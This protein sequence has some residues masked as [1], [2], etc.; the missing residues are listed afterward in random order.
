M[1]NP[2]SKNQYHQE[3]VEDLDAAS[4]YDFAYSV[5]SEKTGDI[6]SHRESRNKDGMVKGVYMFIE[7]DGHKRTVNYYVNKDSGF[8]ADVNREKVSGYKVPEQTKFVQYEQHEQQYEQPKT[9]QVASFEDSSKYLVEHTNLAKLPLQLPAFDLT[10]YKTKFNDDTQSNVQEP[11]KYENDQ[12]QTVQQTEAVQKPTFNTEELHQP[13]NHYQEVPTFLAQEQLPKKYENAYKPFQIVAQ[14]EEKLT[15]YEQH[16]DY[17][18]LETPELK[19]EQYQ[20]SSEHQLPNTE[21]DQSKPSDFSSQYQQEEF[22]QQTGPQ[23]F[24][25]T[26][27]E[28]LQHQEALK[29]EIDGHAHPTSTEQTSIES[30]QFV[31]PKYEVKYDHFELKKEDPSHQQ[32]KYVYLQK[33][34]S[35]TEQN[36]ENLVSHQPKIMSEVQKDDSNVQ[37]DNQVKQYRFTPLQDLYKFV[38]NKA[39]GVEGAEPAPDFLQ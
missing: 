25:P 10:Q 34:E 31:T 6:K 30:L 33:P 29:Y 19:Y 20:L 14:E 8:V 1:A 21:L 23:Q 26:Y 12:Y 9:V 27:L 28:H 22:K 2:V 5:H 18:P 35:S 7:P 39:K 11:V 15:K 13:Q 16:K 32:V 4:E 36:N 3:P 38:I 24:Y 37:N 17:Q